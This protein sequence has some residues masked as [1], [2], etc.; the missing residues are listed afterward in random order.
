[1][2]L[3]PK[4]TLERRRT[5]T[6]YQQPQAIGPTFHDLI[7]TTEQGIRRKGVRPT[8]HHLFGS[9]SLPLSVLYAIIIVK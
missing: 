6:V 2:N 8:G 5:R 1:M 3:C 9:C 7:E 4:W